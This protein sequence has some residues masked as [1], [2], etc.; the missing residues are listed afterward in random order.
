MTHEFPD[1]SSDRALDRYVAVQ[2]I[3][4]LLIDAHDSCPRV[5][6]DDRVLDSMQGRGKEILQRLRSWVYAC[7]H[8]HVRESLYPEIRK[9]DSEL[10]TIRGSHEGTPDSPF[11]Y[12][13][14]PSNVACANETTEATDTSEPMPSVTSARQGRDNP[15]HASRL[16]QEKQKDRRYARQRSD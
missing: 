7:R 13:T 1:I 8:T 3:E 6:R 16:V 4:R 9:N 12:S 14:S 5:Y 11:G 2:E 15:R 10:F